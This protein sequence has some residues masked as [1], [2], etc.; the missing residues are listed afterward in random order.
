MT[1]NATLKLAFAWAIMFIFSPAHAQQSCNANMTETAP[2]SRFTVN[3]NQTVTDQATGLIWK[4]CLQG[5]SGANCI[6]GSAKSVTWQQAFNE[7]QNEDF[8]DQSDWRL[9]NI[10][11]LSS[12]IERACDGPAINI[13]V[14]PR[15]SSGL[16]SFVWSASP[17]NS[18][19][20]DAWIVSFD[21]GSADNVDRVSNFSVRLVRG[22]Q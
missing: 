18:N 8:A 7:A 9:P 11:E 10:K 22:G 13:M 17:F 21:S 14:F 6:T 19:A 15:S 1:N 2:A 20:D 12:I 4:Q 5:L 3:P 16:F